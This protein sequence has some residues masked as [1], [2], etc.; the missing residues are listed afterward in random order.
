[1][2]TDQLL[3][4]FDQHR[5]L[6]FSIAYRMTGNGADAEDMVQETFIRWQGSRVGDSV[7]ARVSGHDHQPPLHQSSAVRA[8]EYVGYWLPEPL[9]TN[10]DDPSSDHRLDE[11]LSMAFLLMLERLSPIERAVFLLSEVFDYQHA[12]VARIVD[13]NE[14]NCRQILKRARQHIASERPRFDSSSEHH[15]ELLQNFF[16]RPRTAT[17]AVS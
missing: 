13:K 4:A 16:P 9:V 12:E 2:V 17:W 1:M 10:M 3:Q 5:A 8:G 11:S 7:A 14:A 15:E 6:L